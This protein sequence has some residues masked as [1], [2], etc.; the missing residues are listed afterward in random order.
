MPLGDQGKL[1]VKIE[2]YD[3]ADAEK[4]KCVQGVV[5]FARA[6]ALAS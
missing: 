4:A 1:E 5:V 3:K 6:K 2:M